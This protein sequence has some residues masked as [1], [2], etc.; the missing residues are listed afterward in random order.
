MAWLDVAIAR[1][2][3]G[4]WLSPWIATGA[5]SLDGVRHPL[6]GPGRW[7]ATSVAKTPEGCRFELPGDGRLGLRGLVGAAGKDFVGWV[8]ADPA[9]GT[10]NH[11]GN[12]VQLHAVAPVACACGSGRLRNTLP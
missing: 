5:L 11:R 6:G 2:R 3:L 10:G 9:G 7:R 4:R 12:G 8:Y 1:V